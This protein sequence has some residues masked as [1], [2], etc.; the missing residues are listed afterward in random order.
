L[1][2]I[3]REEVKQYVTR[4]NN[5]RRN[6]QRVFGLIW[7]Q[8]SSALQAYVKGQQGYVTASDTYNIKWLLQETKK[9]A[10]GIDSKANP[11][12]TMHE[13]VGLM[14]RM[15][16]RQSEPVDA[17]VERFKNNALTFDMVQGR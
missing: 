14:S 5:I 15:R 4:K 7:G 10:N 13:A 3:L 2:A 16:Q 17:Y 6:I 11:Y 12:A 9:A 1:E 8:C